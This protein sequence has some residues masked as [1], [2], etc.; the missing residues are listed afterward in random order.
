LLAL[1]RGFQVPCVLATG[2]DLDVFN[3]L[4]AGFEDVHLIRR[5][6]GMHAVVSARR[7]GSKR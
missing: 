2:A 6:E 1:M 3:L 4:S 7:K 5:D